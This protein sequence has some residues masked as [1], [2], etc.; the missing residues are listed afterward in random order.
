MKIIAVDTGG[1]F[2]DLVMVDTNAK[3]RQLA[4]VHSVPKNPEMGFLNAADTVLDDLSDVDLCLYGTTVA[5]NSIIQR[6]GAKVGMIT[7]KGFRDV[8][9]IMR[10][11]RPMFAAYDLQWPKTEPLVPRYLRVEVNERIDFE[12]NV[13][14]PLQR[15]EIIKA[16]K[17]LAGHGCDA[18]A[19]CFMQSY[20][21]PIHEEEAL[22]IVKELDP[23]LSVSVSSR[24]LAQ[25][26]EYERFSTAVVDAFMKPVLAGHLKKL[27]DG[28]H[29]RGYKYSLMI[30]KSNGGVFTAQGAR[31][32]PAATFSSGPA[33]GV[34]AG[35]FYGRKAGFNNVIVNDVGGTSADLCLIREGKHTYTTETEVA[36][37]IPLKIPMIDV[38][39]IGAGGGSIGWLDPAGAI[40]VGPLSAG[41][42][43]GPACYGIGG[44]KPT[45]TDANLILG[46]LN[47]KNFLGGNQEL[48]PDLALQSIENGL[49]K[50]LGMTVNDAAWGV[51][52]IAVANMV[53][54]ARVISAQRGWDP[55]E[56]ALV[57][58]GGAGP[59]HGPLMARELGI[60]YVVI[61]P[62]P[63]LMSA[64]GL[65]L[66]DL[67]FDMVQSLPCRLDDGGLSL[68]K[69]SLNELSK[70]TLSE[71]KVE[72]HRG[73]IQ[74]E[75]STDLRYAG[76]NYEINL[77]IDLNHLVEDTLVRQFDNEHKRLYGFANVGAPIEIINARVTGVGK[78]D[79]GAVENLLAL[80]PNGNSSS[81]SLDS[82]SFR[83]VYDEIV[84]GF[85]DTPIFDRMNLSSGQQIRGP[86][87]IEEMD[88]TT[89]IPSDS[90]A[91]L[92]E[93]GNLVIVLS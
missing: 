42:N 63:G 26:R 91:T 16:T 24:I 18:I 56:F 87:I 21:N 84:D 22:E 28:L 8:I 36:T 2:S 81:S 74:V 1:T 30:M 48:Y 88:S 61:P 54:E 90:S 3:S 13:L 35:G 72:G 41:A 33:S 15:D 85:I 11:N 65:L 59:L 19:I 38:R 77:Q 14:I 25:Q 27:E 44:E 82:V 50:P 52:Q 37:G 58:A 92:D 34:I 23:D 7:T 76:Q 46:R 4:K 75:F 45:L 40:K 93:F 10:G 89:H 71:I 47:P 9:E 51:I 73:E 68:L 32:L 66:T 62:H 55:R 53:K 20:R 78:V 6:V 31:R 17:F 80:H 79:L 64:S 57:A 12:G 86:A 60:K 43:P 67:K 70:R 83:N 69:N 29:E 5:T 39:S 49:A